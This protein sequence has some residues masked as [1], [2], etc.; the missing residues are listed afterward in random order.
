MNTKLVSIMVIVVA[1]SVGVGVVAMGIN[2]FLHDPIDAREIQDAKAKLELERIAL[3]QA[4]LQDKREAIPV[5]RN[6]KY[7]SYVGFTV[8]VCLAGCIVA[9]AVYKK[10]T[11]HIFRLKD[12]EIPI[13]DKDLSRLAPEISTGLVL[14]SQ[15]EAEAPQKAFD[16]Y[17]RMAEVNAAQLRAISGKGLHIHGD[18]LNGQEVQALPAVPAHVPTF[19]ELLRGGEIAPGKSLLF[20]MRETGEPARGTWQDLY[21]SA[22][23]GQS[24]NGKSSTARSLILQS[25]LS[26]EIEAFYLADPHRHKPEG[27]VNT[28]GPVVSLP[29]IVFNDTNFDLP[30]IIATFQERMQR[31]IDGKEPCQRPIVLVVDELL[32]VV[33]NVSGAGDVV[34]QIGTEGR[35]FHCYGLFLAQSWVGS[36]VGGTSARDNLTS[37]LVH[38]LKKKQASTLLQDA[39][40]SKVA[41]GLKP[42][43]II[44]E[45]TS[46][47]P[48]KLSVPLCT[49]ADAV[50]VY[51]MVSDGNTVKVSSDIDGYFQSISRHTEAVNLDVNPVVNMNPVNQ[52]VNHTINRGVN[53]TE[54]NDPALINHMAACVE[55]GEM[56]QADVAKLTGVST[57]FISQLK[58]GKKKLSPDMREKLSAVLSQHDDPDAHNIIDL[59]KAKADRGQ[60]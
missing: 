50:T 59:E 55:H 28:L 60:K 26:G 18:V 14:A 8:S 36:E 11:V 25:L 47:D 44:F 57:A 46:D 22:I 37:L 16:L 15:I 30:G 52:D 9:I 41:S 17:I 13:K 27:L 39:E 20:G 29:N 40:W 56:T 21:S 23:A 58:N 48:F 2:F 5:W 42:G 4:K 43:E 35:G 6:V 34:R 31:R 12:A 45:P 1:A 49:S 53:L 32:S 33:K 38:R 51:S 24:G 10:K 7:G 19:H 54:L 3:K